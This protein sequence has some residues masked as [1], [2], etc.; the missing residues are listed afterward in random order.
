[1]GAI[2]KAAAM[3]GLVGTVAAGIF[4]FVAASQPPPPPAAP[5]MQLAAPEM[6]TDAAT[7]QPFS[8]ATP[9]GA[10]QKLCA[11]IE[12]DDHA[13]I[14]ECLCDDGKDPAMAKLGHEM[15]QGMASTYRIEKAWKDKWGQDMKVSGLSF[16]Q[17][18]DGNYQT[19]IRGTADGATDVT[20]D[21]DEAR[22]RV[23]VAAE[24]FTGTG[25]DRLVALARWSGAMLVFNKI[26]GDWKLNTDRTFNLVVQ[27]FRIS[28]NTTD[29]SEIAAGVAQ[30][31]V[32]ALDNI[33]GQIESGQITARG[34][35]AVQVETLVSHV[36]QDNKVSG[37]S[38][39]ALPVIGGGG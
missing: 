9:L 11:A 19:L 39:L 24:K 33:A 36:F 12:I 16:D 6:P 23:P 10:L 17:F 3:F 25:P 2:P 1:M 15:I 29:S 14:E 18:P 26:D 22:I 31:I 4:V 28:G 38:Y 5:A 32:G 35:A 30:G 21:G 7:T 20:Y 13:T 27:V 37:T 8:Q 34:R